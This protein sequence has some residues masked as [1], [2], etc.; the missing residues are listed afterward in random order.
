MADK[1][2]EAGAKRLRD[3]RAELGAHAGEV[4]RLIR[5]L[6]DDV[7]DL[8]SQ[9][10]WDGPTASGAHDWA[11]DRGMVFRALRVGR[12]VDAFADHVEKSL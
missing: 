3:R 1:L 2:A 9:E 11:S 5:E 7:D 8:H 6:E 12:V 4:S 10:G